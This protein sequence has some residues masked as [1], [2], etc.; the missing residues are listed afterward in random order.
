VDQSSFRS[1]AGQAD[2]IRNQLGQQT[3]LPFL[4]LLSTTQVESTCRDW[5]HRWRSR[6]DTPWITLSMFLLQVLSSDHLH[7]R[8]IR[9]LL[10]FQNT[11]VGVCLRTRG[12]R[13]INELDETDHPK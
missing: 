1:I 3:G 7:R 9:R 11:L 2:A 10:R 4:E 6:I 12:I 8:R 5:N 13:L